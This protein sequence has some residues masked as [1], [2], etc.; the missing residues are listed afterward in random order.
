[1]LEGDNKY[2]C[3]QYDRK[4][5]VMKRSCIK[6]LPNTLVITLKRFE[7]DYT[8]YQRVKI[9]DY[10]EFPLVLDMHPWTSDYLNSDSN[11]TELY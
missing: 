2:L 8:A 7:F 11:R 9:N 10:F 4:I 3:E 5:K 1:M 6:S